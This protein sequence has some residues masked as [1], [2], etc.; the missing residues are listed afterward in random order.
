MSLVVPKA[1][2]P[3]DEVSP[4]EP[5]PVAISPTITSGIASRVV[6]ERIRNVRS[7]REVRYTGAAGFGYLTKPTFV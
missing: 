5:H 4:P 2:S 6:I 3:V 7:F 1:A